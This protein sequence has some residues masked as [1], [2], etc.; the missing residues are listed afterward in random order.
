MQIGPLGD[1]SGLIWLGFAYLFFVKTG[2]IRDHR[3]FCSAPS[4]RGF[5]KPHPAGIFYKHTADSFMKSP[6]T[7]EPGI[8]RIIIGFSELQLQS[9]V[10]RPRQ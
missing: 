8:K 4:S 3:T 1:H 7:R 6:V 2:R 5:E 10:P 9:D